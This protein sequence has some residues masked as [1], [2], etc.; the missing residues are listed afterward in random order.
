M[1]P[2]GPP[3]ALSSLTVAGVPTMGMGNLFFTGNWY[4]CDYA[5]GS[6]G[7]TGSADNPLKTITRAH[8]LATAGNN[9][10]IVIVGD[11]STTATQ[12][13]T[14]TLEWSKNATHLIGMTAPVPYASRARISHAATA[15]S[16]AF[17]PMVLVT[18]NG[19]VFADF[20]LFEGF[21]QTGT[22]VITWED[23]GTRNLYSR[24]QFGGMGNLT[25]NTSAAQAGSASLLLTGGGEHFFDTCVIGLDT[26]ARTAANASLRLR[27]QVARCWFQNC[28]F[29]AYYTTAQTQLFVDANASA[30]LNRSLKFKACDFHNVQG[31]SGSTTAT[32]VIANN[33]AQNG[34]I[35]LVDCTMFGATDWTAADASNVLLNMPAPS[36]DAGGIMV[37]ID[38]TP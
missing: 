4:F 13:I 34:D 9:D 17:T 6:D 19:C 35:L 24:V 22:A 30:S 25:A 27:S 5:N 16:T 20:S 7:N 11:G 2:S 10:V 14:E 38:V 18:A 15:P 23:R 32:A 36:D 29:P 33:A 26:V 8:D 3:T 1:T 28:D 21:A 31:I 37:P 12:R